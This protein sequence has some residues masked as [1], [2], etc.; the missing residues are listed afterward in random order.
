MEQF[1]FVF[2]YRVGVADINYGGH[3]A[4]SAV[5]NIFQDARIAFFA[6]LGPYSELDLGGCGIIMPEAHVYYRNEMFLHDELQVAVRCK[7]LKR[8]SFLLEYRIER[9]GA[10]TAEG[11]TPIV[12]FD[13]A[14]R[15]PCRIP[16]EFKQKITESMAA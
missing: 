9:C 6:S 3:V 4:N 7:D 8:S 12:C 16:E 1:P 11:E 2:P 10:V 14:K 13:Y 5:L 15:K